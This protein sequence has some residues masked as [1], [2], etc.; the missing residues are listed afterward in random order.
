MAGPEISHVVFRFSGTTVIEN[1]K[2]TWKT[3]STAQRQWQGFC[4]LNPFHAIKQYTV[5]S[6]KEGFNMGKS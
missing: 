5:Q 4:V 1:E 3:P 2:I 6:A